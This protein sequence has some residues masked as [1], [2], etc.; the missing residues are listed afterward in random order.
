M[1]EKYIRNLSPFIALHLTEEMRQ[2]FLKDE[3][4]VIKVIPVKEVKHG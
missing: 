1:T 4:Q 2:R 3:R